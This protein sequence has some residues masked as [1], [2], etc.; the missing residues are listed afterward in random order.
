VAQLTILVTG[1]TDGIG[2]QAALDCARQ[3][4]RVLV[5]ARSRQR[6]E[7]VLDELRRAAGGGN[8]ELVVADLASLDQ[9]RALARELQDR[10]GHLDVLINNAAVYMKERVLTPDGFETTF[11][12]NH[13][14]P[15]LLTGL[16]M[17]LLKAAPAA[18]V[19]NVASM[20]YQGGQLEYDNLQGERRFDGFSAYALSKLA[21]VM[22]TLELAG[23]LGAT[24]ITANCLHPGVV[25]TKLLTQGFG[26]S[27]IPVERG[28]RT[29]TYLALSP[30]VL[31]RSGGYYVD[32]RPTPVA[33]LARESGVRTKL[34][35]HTE[36]LVGPFGLPGGDPQEGRTPKAGSPELRGP[37]TPAPP[38][39]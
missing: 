11:A 3:G 22:F 6:G 19:V 29:V 37:R 26:F 31:A 35:E 33:G 9:V 4:M 28:S 7:P 8:L 27:G 32:C 13:L 25:T 1:A 21:N 5:H 23:R 10:I 15:F 2:R 38:A 36:A 20:A 39:H 12:V 34:W 14:A 16:V 24:A 17:D 30:E 18:R